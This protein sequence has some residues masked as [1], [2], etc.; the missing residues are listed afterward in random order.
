MDESLH[1][2]YLDSFANL[3][4]ELQAYKERFACYCAVLEELEALTIGED[5]KRRLEDSLRFRI[6][7]LERRS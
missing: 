5:E 7:E 4:E 3:S 1:R 6:A 2:E